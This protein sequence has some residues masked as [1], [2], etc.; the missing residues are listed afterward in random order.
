[1]SNL[2]SFLIQ[3][4]L[5]ILKTITNLYYPPKSI[6]M[7][8]PKKYGQSKIDRCPFC[9]K[10]ATNMNSQ[11]VPVCSAH[12]EQVLDGLK[13][14]CGDTLDIL[15]GKF[16]VYFSCMRCGNMN[17]KKVLEV[18]DV[19]A[20]IREPKESDAGRE[21]KETYPRRQENHKETSAS[22]SNNNRTIITVR[23]DDPRYF[24]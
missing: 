9:Q 22:K 2:S 3:I 16:G 8:I 4:I 18:N 24:D 14:V 21:N 5:L 12:K 1:M 6:N 11:K 20:K 10:H 23:S 19:K 15:H 13:C 7:Y 17:L